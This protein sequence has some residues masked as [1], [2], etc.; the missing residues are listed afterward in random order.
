M[1]LVIAKRSTVSPLRKAVLRGA[2]ASFVVY[3][4]GDARGA[5]A[6]AGLGGLA[7]L[8]AWAAARD[9]ALVREGM[10]LTGWH[11]VASR[12]WRLPWSTWRLGDDV[13]SCAARSGAYNAWCRLGCW[14]WDRVY[15]RPWRYRRPT[16]V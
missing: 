14:L 6:L 15:K 7:F 10:Y 12:L 11:A 1:I 9:F 4:M 8:L 3:A 13:V 2:A 5:L 16:S